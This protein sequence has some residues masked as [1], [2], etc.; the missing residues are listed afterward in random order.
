MVRDHGARDRG[1]MS[2]PP[3]P[4]SPPAP[5]PPPRRL[6]RSR[7]DRVLGGVCGGLAAYFRI[8]P[9]IVRL[10][11]VLLVLAGG[12]GGPLDLAP[13]PLVPADGDEAVGDGPGAGRVATVAGVVVL[14]VALLS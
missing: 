8:D 5:E 6:T 4:P 2:S 7:S 13:R 11:A 1:A 3:A 9:I 10:G 14:A 12:A